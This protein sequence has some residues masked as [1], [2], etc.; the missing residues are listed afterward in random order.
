M[1]D[2]SIKARRLT[3]I[4]RLPSKI[5]VNI[6]KVAKQLAQPPRLVMIAF[7]RQ[8]EAV[9]LHKIQ[10]ARDLQLHLNKHDVD[11]E[12]IKCILNALIYLFQ[13]GTIDKDSVIYLKET[14]LEIEQGTSVKEAVLKNISKFEP[15]SGTN[16][17]FSPPTPLNQSDDRTQSRS[18][19]SWIDEAERYEEQRN[20]GRAA[21]AFEEAAKIAAENKNNG[22]SLLLWQKAA[23]LR[24]VARQP[25]EE[26]FA[27]EE[28]AKMASSLQCWEKS[29][30]LWKKALVIRK[31]QGRD[32][33]IAFVYEEIAK[34]LEELGPYEGAIKYWN[35]AITTYQEARANHNVLFASQM[36]AEIEEDKIEEE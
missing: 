30:S 14:C 34:I 3:P 32:K 19:E 6:L 12:S 27:L 31:E 17:T 9:F 24:S 8:P 33:T 29:L 28:A 22:F 35:L 4:A 13:Q 15:T 16:E 1:S 7:A 26:V 25:R 20:F 11:F 18:I 23:G 2:F 36:L 5:G 10:N 21:Y